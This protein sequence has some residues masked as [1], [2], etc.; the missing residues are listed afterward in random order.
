MLAHRANTA[1]LFYGFAPK[2][3]A[4]KTS[5]A[6]EGFCGGFAWCVLCENSI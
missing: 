3:K 4:D 5:C 1:G 2:N 6:V